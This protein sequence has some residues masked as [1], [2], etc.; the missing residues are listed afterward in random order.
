MVNENELI[1]DYKAKIKSLYILNMNYEQKKRF[2]SC[3]KWLIY[4]FSIVVP[5]SFIVYKDAV[6]LSYILFFLLIIFALIINY[7]RIIFSVRNIK[8]DFS[9]IICMEDATF[10]SKSYANIINKHFPDNNVTE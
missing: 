8:N 10:Y 6:I 7:G 9:K 5:I 2:I 1:K 3:I 4:G